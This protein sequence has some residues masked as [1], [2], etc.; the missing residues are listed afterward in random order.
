MIKT[1]EMIRV[2]PGLDPEIKRES[3]RTK[4]IFDFAIVA[5][6][7]RKFHAIVRSLR[8]HRLAGLQ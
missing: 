2:G 8:F 6:L 5:R 7:A 4:A 3:N 1:S